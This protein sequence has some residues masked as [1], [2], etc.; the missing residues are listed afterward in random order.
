ML[1]R[2][3]TS[4][5]YSYFDDV[6]NERKGTHSRACSK[7]LPPNAEFLCQ[8]VT[9]AQIIVGKNGPS[10]LE[11][12]LKV[13]P[14]L[15]E[16]QQKKQKEHKQNRENSSMGSTQMKIDF[17]VEKQ[18]TS[19]LKQVESDRISFSW[20]NTTTRIRYKNKSCTMWL[21]VPRCPA[22]RW[23][24]SNRASSQDWSVD[25]TR[26]YNFHHGEHWRMKSY[27]EHKCSL[28]RFICLFI[29]QLGTIFCRSKENSTARTLH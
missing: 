27:L 15:Y 5:V 19:V 2:K 13:H 20:Q 17:H 21:H 10:N 7:L 4:N 18:V 1:G 16:E 26:K 23:T 6:R 14:N 22:N 29:E 9:C 8:V 11:K 24:S 12:H 3:R 28:K 25:S